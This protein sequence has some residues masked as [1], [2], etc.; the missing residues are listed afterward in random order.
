MDRKRVVFAIAP[1]NALA[2]SPA[3]R[4]QQ[5]N[6]GFDRG[7][8]TGDELKREMGTLDP[9]S[10]LALDTADTDIILKNL[11]LIYTRARDIMPE[12]FGYSGHGLGD[13]RPGETGCGHTRLFMCPYHAWTFELD[14]RLK[15]SPEMQQ[16]AGFER[17][18]WGL[19]EFNCEVW[20]GLVFV[21]LDGTAGALHERLGGLPAFLTGYRALLD[22]IREKSPGVR[23]IIASPPPL[24]NLAPPLPDQTEPNKNLASLRDALAK[25]AHSQNV[26]FVDW[27]GAMGG[28]PKPGRTAKPLTENGIHYTQE[29]YQKLAAKLIAG[30]GVKVPDVSPTAI[31]P[32][33]KAIVAKDTLFFDRWRPQN[34]TYLFGFRKH[35]QGQNAKEIPMFDPLI[36]DADKKIQEM[37]VSIVAAAKRP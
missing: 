37:K 20:N 26:F 33:R 5:M 16:T 8:V 15:G 32:L 21:N 3:A 27:F 24:E 23:L 1:T 2:K 12:G 13:A 17:D 25:F 7:L 6:E 19:K 10:D 36:A 28:V 22:L 35:E 30:L 34:E 14:G 9:N 18:A 31:E 4:L 11:D 29:G